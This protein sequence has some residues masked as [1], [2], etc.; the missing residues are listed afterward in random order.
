MERKKET[1]G[2]G[3][4]ADVE[5]ATL[6]CRYLGQS[7][8][9]NQHPQQPLHKLT[10]HFNLNRSLLVH[11]THTLTRSLSLRHS[12]TLS[13]NKLIQGADRESFGDGERERSRPLIGME[14]TRRNL[15]Q[16]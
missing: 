16:H 2:E 1:E 14:N 5:W 7:Q 15:V 6:K 11:S 3:G 8:S 4:E 10:G 12:D 9:H 13:K